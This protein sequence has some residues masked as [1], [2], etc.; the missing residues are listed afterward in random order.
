[1][2]HW[3]VTIRLDATRTRDELIAA[4]SQWSA[5]WLYRMLHPGVEVLGVR[6]ARK[7]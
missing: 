2:T 1:M 6:P 4:R 5:G 3:Y 7:P